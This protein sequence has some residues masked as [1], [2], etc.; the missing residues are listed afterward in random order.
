MPSALL[1]GGCVLADV[2]LQTVGA[3]GKSHLNDAVDARLRRRRATGDPGGGRRARP[4]ARG[5]TASDLRPPTRRAGSARLRRRARGRGGP[6]P[7]SRSVFL[8]EVAFSQ[9]VALYAR[10]ECVALP[11]KTLIAESDGVPLRIHSGRLLGPGECSGAPLRERWSAADGRSELRATQAA[12]AGGV[13][14]LHTAGERRRLYAVEEPPDP[15]EPLVCPFLGLASFDVAHAE[16]FFSC[17]RRCRRARSP[18][19]LLDPARGV[20]PLRQRQVLGDTRRSPARARRRGRPRLARLA[21]GR[22]CI[23]RA[24]A[25]RALANPRPRGARGRERERSP[26]DRRHGRSVVPGHSVLLCR[27]DRSSSPLATRPS[28]EDFFEK[29]VERAPPT[30]SGD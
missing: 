28:N 20:R 8:G 9:I 24:P 13:V 29:L 5:A 30:P 12:I 25:R 14:D 10:A 15:S 23:G 21:P 1:L 3:V 26:V 16:Y 19:R 27:S 4:R 17:E 7:A 11:L 6:P 2:A 18:A 22:R